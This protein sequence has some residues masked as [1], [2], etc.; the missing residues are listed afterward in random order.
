MKEDPIRKRYNRLAVIYDYMEAPLERFRFAS[1]R[2][3]LPAYI[4]GHRILEVG[5]GTGKNFPYYPRGVEVTAIDFSHAML[6]RARKKESSHNVKVK[7]IGMDI[8]QLAFPDNYFDSI[9]ATFVFCSVGDP[10]RGLQELSRV[11][12]PNGRLCLIEHV[13]PDN[14]ILGLF[15]DLLNPVI[16]RIMGANINRRTL[17]N[18]H[19]SGWNIRAKERLF[20]DIVWWIEAEPIKIKSS[21]SPLLRMQ[22][23]QTKR[24]SG[25]TS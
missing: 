7:L 25:E 3:R 19:R 1:W 8:Q 23:R 18:I 2:N 10:V 6:K 20:S 16:V 22:L 12:K 17:A 11:C 21:S 9:F 5:V 15:F 13:R 4:T 14:L 24:Q